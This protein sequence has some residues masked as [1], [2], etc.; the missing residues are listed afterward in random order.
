MFGVR[1]HLQS[2]LFQSQPLSLAVDISM[3]PSSGPRSTVSSLSSR[4]DPTSIQSQFI[5]LSRSRDSLRQQLQQIEGER[6]RHEASISLLKQN[7]AA[8]STDHNVL[9]ESLGKHRMKKALLE[10]EKVRLATLFKSERQQLEMIGDGIQQVEETSKQSKLAFCKQLQDLSHS[11]EDLIQKHQD[12]YWCS[13]LRDDKALSI[14]QNFA[15]SPR[16]G[17]LPLAFHADDDW[18]A[19][20][21]KHVEYT[22]LR[23]DMMT[24]LHA[25]RGRANRMEPVC[26]QDDQIELMR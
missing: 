2:H 7:C 14:L 21:K 22:E 1:R 9:Q 17:G 8:L 15:A 26:V 19:A 3:M 16:G 6:R 18:V 25:F 4:V 23:D 11:L 20:V 13:L 5:A 12:R 24:E 10:K